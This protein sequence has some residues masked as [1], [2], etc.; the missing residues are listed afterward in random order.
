MKVFD[1][2][3]VRENNERLVVCVNKD[4]QEAGEIPV[5][6]TFTVKVD[7]TGMNKPV[8]S[9]TEAIEYSFKKQRTAIIFED[10]CSGENYTV[11]SDISVESPVVHVMIYSHKEDTLSRVDVSTETQPAECVGDI[12]YFTPVLYAFEKHIKD[13]F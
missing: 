6:N 4:F 10:E 12:H 3:L 11:I 9:I 8:M 5:V 13:N 7:F 2:M 1:A